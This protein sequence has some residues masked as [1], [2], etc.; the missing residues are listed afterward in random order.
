M[1][2]K[3]VENMFHWASLTKIKL[4]CC[5]L[6]YVLIIFSLPG[7]VVDAVFPRQFDFQSFQQPPKLSSI[8]QIQTR[9]HF[10]G[11]K[12]RFFRFFKNGTKIIILTRAGKVTNFNFAK[13]DG[14]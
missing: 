10:R 7:P 13:K 4:S 3:L 6:L 14:A 8:R 9:L 5:Q 12:N 2:Q 11:E 1:P